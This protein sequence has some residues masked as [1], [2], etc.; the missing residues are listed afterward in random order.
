MKEL[1]VEATIEN[2]D[3]VTEFV[4][5]QLEE[6]DCPMKAQM[7]IDVAIDELFSNIAYYAYNPEIGRATVRV[8]VIE[9]PLAVNIS[10]IDNGVPYDPLAKADPDITLSAEERGIGGLG[11]YMVKKTMDDVTYEYK[12]GQNILKIKKH[13]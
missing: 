2:I 10:F 11:I 5:Q 3:T 8:E 9:D 1:N 6:L 13:L 7:Q 4:N 12:D